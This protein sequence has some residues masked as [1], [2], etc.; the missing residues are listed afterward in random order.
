MFVLTLMPPPEL[1]AEHIFRPS[2]FSSSPTRSACAT[3]APRGRRRWRWATGTPTPERRRETVTVCGTRYDCLAL[4]SLSR[5]SMAR[6]GIRADGLLCLPAGPRMAQVDRSSFWGLRHLPQDHDSR[7]EGPRRRQELLV[8]PR[9]RRCGPTC[10]R[11]CRSVLTTSL[12][13]QEEIHP[14]SES[15]RHRDVPLHP[16]LRHG[17]ARRRVRV[18][19]HAPAAATRRAPR[20]RQRLPPDPD[21]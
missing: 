16:A 20:G 5:S 17:L 4:P 6:T 12:A 1:R 9:A 8:R 21:S 15:G 19:R 2:A 14:A 10:V 3:S 18:E 7:H 11:D 13:L